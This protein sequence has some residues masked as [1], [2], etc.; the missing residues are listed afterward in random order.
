M[1]RDAKFLYLSEVRSICYLLP[2]PQNDVLGTIRELNI[3]AKENGIELYGL[4]VSTSKETREPIVSA[5]VTF[6]TRDDFNFYGLPAPGK[7]RQFTSISYDLLID[8][9]LD[10]DFS[11]DYLLRV[12]DARFK[13][14]RANY[15]DNPYDLIVEV[16]NR[17]DNI[18]FIKSIF[19]Y[20]SS[21]NNPK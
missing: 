17:G 10:Y 11:T 2:L 20:I 8:F 9:S 12:T 5:G 14:G 13:V 6:L 4:A 15:N 18:A 16:E 21:I 3:V 19:K 1:R 7:A